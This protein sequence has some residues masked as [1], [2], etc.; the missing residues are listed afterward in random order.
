MLESTETS[1]SLALGV[2]RT[3]ASHHRLKVKFD[4]CGD[5]IVLGRHGELGEHG[6]G[7]LNACFHGKGAEPFS[8]ARAG[9]IRRTLA[10]DVGE[11]I[12]GS[13]GADEALF[14][15]EW[16]D[17]KAATWFIDSLRI[18][19]RRSVSPGTAERLRRFARMRQT[20][21]G[22]PVQARKTPEG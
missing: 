5:P 6:D 20:L 2:L 16:T 14:A 4:G 15:F 13:A 9:R 12:S 11:L 7:R 17:R 8:R 21:A 3:F 19:R 22:R 18:R 10:L 1:K